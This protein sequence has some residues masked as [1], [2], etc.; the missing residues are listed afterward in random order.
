MK[1]DNRRGQILLLFTLISVPLFGMLGLVTDLGYMHYVKMTAQS[2]AE[3]AAQSAIVDFHATMGGASFTCG[4]NVVCASSQTA[5][6]AGITMPANSIEHGCMYGQAHGFNSA[7][8]LTYQSGVSSAPPTA[9]GMTT[10]PYWVTF[11]AY[12][13]VPQMFSA[14]LGNFSGTV[15]GRS[16]AAVVGA[17]DCIYALDPTAPGAINVQGTASLSSACGIFVDSNNNCAMQSNGGAT[18]SAPEY[19]VVGNVCTNPLTPTPN[20]GVVPASDPLA[21]LA[22]P[23]TG[24]Y[25]CPG[26]GMSYPPPGTKNGATISISPGVY[27]GGIQVKNNTVNFQPGTYVL[28]GGGLTTQDSNSIINGTGVLFYNTFDPTDSQKAYN[29]YS[30]IG[31]AANSVV[32]L[33]APTTGTYAGMLFFDDRSAPSGNPDTY[34]GGSTA[35]YQGII[36]NRNNGITMYGNS[37]VSQYS[38][39]IADTINLVGTTAINDNYSSLPSGFSPLQKVMVV[40]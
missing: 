4:G 14:V 29:T 18:I 19:D 16:T 35:V 40:E 20:T 7:G 39:I 21:S 37:S 26:G 6:A 32:S 13:T 9:S 30:P 1:I 36:Y 5:C 3:A 34:G 11:R 25:G 38:M 2:A 27:C 17:I 10:A 33:T 12:K 31:I 8:S 23:A 24:P 15:V 28:V 22:P